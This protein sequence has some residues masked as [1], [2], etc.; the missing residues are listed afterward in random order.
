MQKIICLS[1][2]TA[3]FFLCGCNTARTFSTASYNTHKDA[4]RLTDEAIAMVNTQAN[5]SLQAGTIDELQFALA[6]NDSVA[7]AAVRALIGVSDEA[8]DVRMAEITGADKE[9]STSLTLSGYVLAQLVPFFDKGD[10]AQILGGASALAQGS[11]EQ[12]RN[13]LIENKSGKVLD[14][15]LRAHRTRKREDLLMQMQNGVAPQ[16]VLTKVAMYHSDC[17]VNAALDAIAKAVKDAEDNATA[18]GV[19]DAA[20]VVRIRRNL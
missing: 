5:V 9:I 1:V 11:E 4:L 3:A 10:T 16:D 20:E 6:D 17:G 19:N 15:A 7:K 18:N 12:L 2:V 14:I 8:C 13:A